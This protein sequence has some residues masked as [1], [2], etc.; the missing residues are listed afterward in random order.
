MPK[1]EPSDIAV[2]E[3]ILALLY[4]AWKNP[5]GM[6]SHKLKISQI[7]GDL[8][9]EG[10][11]KK[12]VVRNLHYLL[13]TGWAIEDVKESQYYTGTMSIPTEKKT[14]RIAK[15]GIDYFDGSNKF[16]K[17]SRFAGINISD[18]NNSVIILGDNNFV[19]NEYRELF[20]SLENL[21]RHIRISSEIPSDEKINYQAEID[22]IKAQ[23]MK[24]KPDKDIIRKAWDVLKGVATIN[25]VV[26]FAAKVA[27]L[28]ATLVT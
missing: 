10:I 1:I 23:L 8:K 4:N 20:E 17:S 2:R 14:Y 22:T 9:K 21:G 19:R 26:S 24:Q 13:E 3:A 11:E 16:Q 15:D 6:D 27:P 18:I 12:Y 5:R 7:T 28:V 25:G